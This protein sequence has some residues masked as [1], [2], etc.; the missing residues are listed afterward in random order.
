MVAGADPLPEQPAQAREGYAAALR[1]SHGWAKNPNRGTGTAQR[2]PGPDLD[3]IQLA[4]ALGATL[5]RRSGVAQ[6]AGHFV[7]TGSVATGA[8]CP[9]CALCGFSASSA[10]TF[11]FPLP[12]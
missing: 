5:Q 7:A 2:R 9:G 1:H 11:P 4:S 8:R 6:H 3:A 12:P 10:S